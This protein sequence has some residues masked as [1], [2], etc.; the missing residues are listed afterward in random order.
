MVFCLSGSLNCSWAL[1][2][3]PWTSLCYH[4]KKKKTRTTE[5][6]LSTNITLNHLVSNILTQVFFLF[7]VELLAN[8]A[9]LHLLFLIEPSRQLPQ[10]ISQLLEH[11]RSSILYFVRALLPLHPPH[12]NSQAKVVMNLVKNLFL[13]LKQRLMGW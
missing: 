4:L 6:K 12:C 8:L 9:S 11:K 13:C 5:F 1:P 3:F 7:L 2:H 10:Q